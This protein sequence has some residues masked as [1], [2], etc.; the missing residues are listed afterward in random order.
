[1]L[2]TPYYP[3]TYNIYTMLFFIGAVYMGDQV[4]CVYTVLYY[5]IYIIH[6]I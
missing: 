5:T 4:S 2:C 6:S 3:I 1:M